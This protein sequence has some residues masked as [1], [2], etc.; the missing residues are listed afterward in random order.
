[1]LFEAPN[2]EKCAQLV[3]ED[4]GIELGGAQP[5]VRRKERRSRFLVPLQTG[6]ASRPPFFLV[7]GM[8][9]N[10]LNLRH[11]AHLGSDQTVRGG[12]RAC[13]RRRAAPPL[14]DMARD[15]LEEVRGAA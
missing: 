6:S 9:G 5:E 1:V 13:R 12:A 14:P 8:F 15:Y 4:L 11:L 7:A 10:V 2:I 3:R